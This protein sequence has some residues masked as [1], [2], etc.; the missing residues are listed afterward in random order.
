[1]KFNGK[2]I[3]ELL[4]VNRRNFIKLAVGGAV[5]TGL[6]PLPWKLTDD[7]TI[8]TQNFPW[9]PVPEESKFT[10]VKSHCTLCPGG[11]GVEVR[12]SGKRAVKIEGRTDHP[13]N[14]GGICPLGMGGLQLLYNENI[15]FTG[16]MKRIGPRGAGKFQPVSWDEALSTLAHKI[17][18]L[19]NKGKASSIVT[20]DGNNKGSTTSAMIE[21]FT[22]AVGSPN[23]M[24]IPASEDTSGIAT[25]LMFG[26]T[27]NITYDLENSDYILSFGCGLLEGWGAPGRVLNAW[28]LWKSKDLKG[29]VNIVQVESRASNTASKADKWVPARPGTETAL[30]L[31][32]AHI[33]IK[34]GLYDKTFVE[35]NTN[36][37]LPYE[38]KDGETYKGF[39]QL[40]L[41][42]Y[43]PE[44]VSVITGI[45]VSD[46][47]EIA[48]TFSGADAPVAVCGKGKGLL[49]GDA[50]EY[51]AA[52][53]LNAL[54]GRINKPGGL[55]ICDPLPLNSFPDIEF[56]DIAK[57][58]LKAPPVDLAEDVNNSGQSLFNN[59]TDIILS[60]EKPVVDTMLVFSSNPAFT[61]PDGGDFNQS[62]TKT[63]FVVSFSP[64]HD[65]T[66]LMADLIIPDHTY[67][68]KTDEVVSPATVQYPFY[69][70]TQ[71]VIDP[72]YDT[73]N[74]GDVILSLAEM[75]GGSV[76]KSFPWKTYDDV[77]N[78]RA[79]GLY[80]SGEGITE[81]NPS[82]PAW[83]LVGKK[84]K[85][86]PDY[87]DFNGLWS[88]LKN[89]GMWYNPTFTIK[90]YE[91][92]FMTESGK[93]EFF[94]KNIGSILEGSGDE[95][96]IT[97][98]DSGDKHKNMYPLKMVP[99][100]I[101]NL[102]SGWL[103]NPP[104]LNKT[105]L[106]DQ[107]IKNDSFVEINP[108][109]AE[110]YHLGEAEKITITSRK[111]KVEARVHLFDGAMPGII[112]M[113]M[114]FGHTA[115]DAFARGKGC[116]PNRIMTGNRDV[117][118][119]QPAWWSTPV[120]I[121]KVHI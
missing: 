26:N 92:L 84:D 119:G 39:K 18:E 8:F 111:G 59:L 49:N 75:I 35:N 74:C 102:S 116:S 30:A 43:T 3:T 86:A 11:C 28:G 33:I 14:P 66:A 55:I 12:K 58:A 72:V 106:D 73:R 78:F 82:S 54:T 40:V 36:G 46:I 4:A 37:F 89:G 7:T 112:Y 108:E 31:G 76:E 88:K 68:E 115:F 87:E 61:L 113:P 47:T 121:N 70:L 105:L 22:K 19:R 53:A 9:V 90:S 24:K 20:V 56:D 1:M 94:N 6:S 5:G 50:L 57:E 51:M 10:K 67:L 81:Y 120:R 17:L 104:Y 69:G 44:K 97:D 64:Y 52:Y 114:G 45:S 98:I 79:K 95:I 25:D 80:E 100:E 15:R 41:E 65:E 118:S 93:F 62:L 13:I 48:M 99:Y 27:G 42:H 29:K 101:I 117:I 85:T 38:T 23:Y 32:I 83:S 109:T 110:K 16:P 103:P 21:R 2:N 77:L 63:P 34:E 107:L 96:M 91:D 60:S 71:P